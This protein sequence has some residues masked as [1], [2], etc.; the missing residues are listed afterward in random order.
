MPMVALG[1]GLARRGHDV[2]V[3]GSAPVVTAV[4]AEG[5][6]FRP[7]AGFFAEHGDLAA[8]L[9]EH[10]ADVL[11]VDYMLTA[12]LSAAEHTALPTVALVHTLYQCVA[13]AP[14]S[15]MEMAAGLD[16]VN[17]HRA[18]LGLPAVQRVTDLLDRVARVIVLATV[19]L[20]RP[21]VPTPTNVRHVGPLLQDAGADAGWTPPGGQEDPLVVVSLGTTPM[22]EAPAIERVL[23]ALGGLPVRGFVTVGDHLDPSSFLCPPNAWVDRYVRHTAVLPHA[24]LLVT[25]AGLG[26]VSAALAYGVPMVCLPLGREQPSNAAKVEAVGAGCTLGPEAPEDELAAAVTAVLDDPSY[27]ERAA[28][29]ATAIQAAGAG[30][31]ALRECE[32]LLPP[33]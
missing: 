4:E 8:A 28:A 31:R 21:D 5:L 13:V 29:M 17:A 15:P 20:D 14:D 7:C 1:R 24:D 22:D 18:E 27:R 11:V 3:L 10:P 33:R 6:A 23:R 25:H 9:E 32:A 30:E 16:D 19:E 2:A 26:S 12:A